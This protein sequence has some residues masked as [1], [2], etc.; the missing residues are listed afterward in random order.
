MSAA[1]RDARGKPIAILSVS[2]PAYR[3][4]RPRLDEIGALLVD[5]AAALETALS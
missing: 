5:A 4:P 1:A 3:I 2:G